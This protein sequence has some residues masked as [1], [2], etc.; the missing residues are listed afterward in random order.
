[1]FPC[2][3]ACVCVL[4]PECFKNTGKPHAEPTANSRVIVKDITQRDPCSWYPFLPVQTSCRTHHSLESTVTQPRF[5]H[6][7][8]P[9]GYP[10]TP[11]RASPSHPWLHGIRS[12]NLFSIA[13]ISL[14][15]QYP[16]NGIAGISF[17]T[18]YNSLQSHPSCD[19]EPVPSYFRV[20]PVGWT[21]QLTVGL[22]TCR[23]GHL[24]VSG[25]WLLW[26]K[27]LWTLRYTGF[28]MNLLVSLG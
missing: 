27:L 24:A 4:I 13:I 3:F 15:G 9:Y 10:F 22:S 26:I 6:P 19:V 5:S 28:P 23:R 11:R 18:Q 2:R 16:L 1:M 8:G 20:P 25:S 12:F 17:L 14:F 21:Y 7:W